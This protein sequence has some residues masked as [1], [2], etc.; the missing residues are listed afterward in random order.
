MINL[1]ASATLIFEVGL[2]DVK[3]NKQVIAKI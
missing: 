2:P 1:T 3:A